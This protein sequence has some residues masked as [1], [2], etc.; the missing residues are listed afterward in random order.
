MTPPT[1]SKQWAYVA[2]LTAVLLAAALGLYSE[3][4]SLKDLLVPTLSL[5]STFFGATFAFRLNQDKEA[6]KLET[7]RREALNRASFVLIRQWNAMDQLVRQFQTYPPPFARAFNMPAFKPPAYEDL[8]HSIAE[9]DYLIDSSNP[10]LLMDLVVEEERFHQALEALRI[11]NE[12]YV[13][14]VQPALEKHELNRKTVTPEQVRAL[15]GERVFE[16]AMNG[17]GTAWEQ[18]FAASES[19]P[20]VH[21]ALLAQGRKLFPGKKFI[22]YERAA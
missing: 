3:V 17:A 8:S 19:L 15:L 5:F 14:E 11:R 2:A 18:I 21:Q 20:K 7:E 16:G 9:L 13:N 4:I 1:A 6:K 12:F 10:G 22:T